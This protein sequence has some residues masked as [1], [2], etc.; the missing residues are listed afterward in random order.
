VT[1]QASSDKD[2]VFVEEDAGPTQS[3]NFSAA[4]AGEKTDGQKRSLPSFRRLQ[5]TLDLAL[6]KRVD[7]VFISPRF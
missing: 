4:H 3:E 6:G 2:A 1:S 7:L 5:E